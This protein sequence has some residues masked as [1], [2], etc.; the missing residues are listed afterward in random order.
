LLVMR[1]TGLRIRDVVT[2]RKD[3]IQKGRLFLRTSKSDTDVFCPLP[4]LVIEALEKINAKGEYFFWSGQSKPKSAVGDY[5]RA[6]KR[7]FKLAETPRVYAHLF[8]HT[9][10]TQLLEDG[11]TLETVATLLGHSNTKVTSK[12]YSHWVKGRPDKL[13]A[14]VKNSWTQLAP[15]AGPPSANHQ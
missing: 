6:L 11:T 1:F 14:A 15:V 5:Q 7:L 2:L 12:S 3:H 13:E 4:P 8:R 10:A 9:F